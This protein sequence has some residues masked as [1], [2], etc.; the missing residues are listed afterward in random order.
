MSTIVFSL[1][2]SH[3]ECNKTVPEKSELTFPLVQEKQSLPKKYLCDDL[4]DDLEKF[5]NQASHD[6]FSFP[7]ALHPYFPSIV[8]NVTV[9]HGRKAVLKCEV[10]NL[11]NY[12]VSSV[13]CC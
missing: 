8:E 11:R 13:N 2:A 6:T 12:K 1:K 9:S 10:D 3:Q 4:R 5:M 7:E